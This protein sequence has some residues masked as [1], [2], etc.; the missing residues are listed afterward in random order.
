[1][2][3]KKPKPNGKIIFIDFQSVVRF[4]RHEFRNGYDHI[5]ERFVEWS[6]RRKNVGIQIT[7][8]ANGEE[9]KICYDNKMNKRI[10]VQFYFLYFNCKDDDDDCEAV[11]Q[12]T[13]PQIKLSKIK[14][15][16]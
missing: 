16:K 9:A 5:T 13:L 6:E 15:N 3:E 10:A 14:C 4:A 11:M 2:K 12:F 7:K 8:I 1:M